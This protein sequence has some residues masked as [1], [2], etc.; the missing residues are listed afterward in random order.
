MIRTTQNA[1]LAGVYEIPA[2][3]AAA[4]AGKKAVLMAHG[5][6]GDKNED[7]D[8]LAHLADQLEEA[9][10]A[11]LRI[12]FC[13]HGDSSRDLAEFTLA[14]QIQDL[15]VAIRWLLGRG[16]TE[17]T[18]LGYSFGAPPVL[19]LASL[20]PEHVRHCVLL[21][22]VTDYR[23]SFVEPD[24]PWNREHFG[25][26]R[27][28]AGIRGNGL[29]LEEGYTLSPAVLT[30]ML[31]CDIPALARTASCPI[32]I[33]HGDRD[34][35][36]SHADSERLC[37]QGSSIT[38][39]TMPQTGHGPTDFDTDSMDS[40]IALKNLADIVAALRGQCL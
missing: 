23:S 24:S 13:G 8:T 11:S 19:A 2:I 34:R 39:R 17:L 15:A 37:R 21:S 40:P 25:R 33:F 38:L 4:D 32:T 14:S 9:G 31:L 20:Y 29:Q 16:H 30:D 3:Y 35:Y 12:D 6:L 7:K 28:L 18:L 1:T 5:L 10:L 26:V 22:P 27:L 36:V